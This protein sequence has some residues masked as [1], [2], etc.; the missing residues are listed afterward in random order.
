MKQEYNQFIGIFEDAF[1]GEFCDELLNLFDEHE[2]NGT[3]FEEDDGE[4][5]PAVWSTPEEYGGNMRRNDFSLNLD[6]L[7]ETMWFNEINDGLFE[8]LDLYKQKYFSL[9]YIK[10]NNYCNPWTKLQKTYPQGGYHIWHYEVDCI[11]E[12]SRVLAWILYLNDIPE[13]E[14]ETEFLFQGVRVKPKKGT[15]VIWPAHFTHPHRGNPVYTKTKYIATGWIEY[16]D[17]VDNHPDSPV[18]YDGEQSSY[19][20]RID[21]DDVDDNGQI[22]DRDDIMN[23]LAKAKRYKRLSDLI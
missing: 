15:L 23:Q 17:V 5:V 11:T 10:I 18:V 1:D 4:I 12:V 3:K 14:G 7:E 6:R 13:G 20:L 22:D 9:E 8:A 19:K 21:E 2:R 16:K